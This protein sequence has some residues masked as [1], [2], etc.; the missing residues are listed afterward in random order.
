MFTLNSYK[1]DGNIITTAADMQNLL[2]VSQIITAIVSKSVPIVVLVHAYQLAA[3]WLESTE[4]K[5]QDR[6]TPLQYGL[7]ITLIQGASV[8]SWLQVYWNLMKPS[9]RTQT[10]TTSLILTC[11]A[12]VLGFLPVLSN[13]VPAFDT[14]FH[15]S[16]KS[17]SVG[18]L[19]E[20]TRS[21][22]PSFTSLGIGITA[23]IESRR[24]PFVNLVQPGSLSRY[25]LFT[26]SMAHQS[27]R[28]RG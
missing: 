6:P 3:R 15:I 20:Y 23:F 2:T 22:L 16:S 28:K 4:R 12:T 25:L 13:A 17:L 26:L 18:T 27:L 14:W 1:R 24:A 11:A 8:P 7:L 5:P 19:S 9:K 10:V 21:T